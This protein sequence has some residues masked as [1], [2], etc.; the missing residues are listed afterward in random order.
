MNFSTTCRGSRVFSWRVVI[1]TVI[2]KFSN[3]KPVET[4]AGGFT[5]TELIM[6]QLCG[7]FSSPSAL[8]AGKIRRTCG[9]L[10]FVNRAPLSAMQNGII[11]SEG[12]CGSILNGAT[13][14]NYLKGVTL[15]E[16]YDTFYLG[17]A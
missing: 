2:T 10:E 1:L 16:N 12:D 9:V 15:G 8:N 17:T 3:N 7:G 5:E 4:L 13:F 14:L 6:A 11:K